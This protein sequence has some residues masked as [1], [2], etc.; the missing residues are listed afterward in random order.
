[1]AMT[2]VERDVL[3][4]ALGQ[5]SVLRQMVAFLL[6]HSAKDETTQADLLDFIDGLL[7]LHHVAR[8][9]TTDLGEQA[10]HLAEAD[11]LA[12]FEKVVKEGIQLPL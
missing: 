6:S 9:E 11:C 8:T 5:I 10:L 12:S 4:E 3:V 1:M 7:V 2:N